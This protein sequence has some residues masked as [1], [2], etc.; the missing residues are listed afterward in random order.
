MAPTMYDRSELTCRG[1]GP[2]PV[3]VVDHCTILL[4]DGTKI[5]VKI[6][7]PTSKAE[8]FIGTDF[9]DLKSIRLIFDGEEKKVEFFDLELEYC[10]TTV[11]SDKGTF[12]TVME[13]IPYRKSDRTAHRDHQRH[14]WMASH[15]Y[16][17]ARPDIRGNGESTGL[18]FDEYSEQEQADGCEIIDWIAS[19]G[20]SNG[21]VGVYGKSWGGFNG[22]QLAYCQPKGLKA[23]IS[24]Y[25]T[26]KRRC[27]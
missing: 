6:W 22:L 25:S 5:A 2:Y 3:S 12:P 24:L 26:G 14:P 18:Y 13:Y 20:W 16:V 10:P 1:I 7:L 23:V 8:E 27:V 21:R 11:I 15:G 19:R 9:G 4:K 17:V